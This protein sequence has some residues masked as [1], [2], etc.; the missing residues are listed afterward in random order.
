MASENYYQPI[1]NNFTRPIIFLRLMRG[2]HASHFQNLFTCSLHM[3]KFL[4]MAR[5]IYRFY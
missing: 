5:A 3:I 2:Y 4:R 1:R